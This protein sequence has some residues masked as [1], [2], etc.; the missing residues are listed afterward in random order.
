MKAKCRYNPTILP[1]YKDYFH[2]KGT[3]DTNHQV[4]IPESEFVIK[5]VIT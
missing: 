3:T 4:D 1:R 5:I 2:L